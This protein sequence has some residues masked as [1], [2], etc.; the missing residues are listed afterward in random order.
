MNIESSP[1]AVGRVALA[2]TILATLVFGLVGPRLAGAAVGPTD[3]A[4]TKSDSA[5]PAVQGQDFAYTIQARNVGTNDAS[6]V[7][8]T[9]ALP[10]AVDYVSSSATVGSCDRAGKHRHLRPRPDQR[11]RC[12]DR[13]DHRQ[14]EEDRDDLEYGVR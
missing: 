14:G 13:D 7:V 2:I 11:R 8:V 4:L 12:R 1:G 6:G 9:D 5:D 3:L 10:S